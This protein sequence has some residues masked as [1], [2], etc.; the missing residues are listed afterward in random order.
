MRMN[1]S[2][3]PGAVPGH[4]HL[5][6]VTGRRERGQSASVLAYWLDW[7]DPFTHFLK[8]LL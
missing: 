4:G 7:R 6:G 3:P 2:A 1:K 5:I 8:G